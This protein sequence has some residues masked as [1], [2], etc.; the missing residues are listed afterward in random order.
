[1]W[2]F[3]VDRLN[4]AFYPTILAF[5]INKDGLRRST[6]LEALENTEEILSKGLEQ[7]A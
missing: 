5:A 2:V 4:V 7:L 6:C 1:M 3:E